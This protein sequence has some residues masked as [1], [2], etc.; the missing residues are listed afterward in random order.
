MT[1]Q[2][3]GVLALQGGFARHGS[4][5]ER[6]GIKPLLVRRADELEQCAGLIIPGG[7]STTMTL[8]MK[9][10]NL[11]TPLKKFASK[12]PIMGTC[13]G[14][15]M[16]STGVD[17]PRVE[18]LDLMDIRADR[19]AYGRQ[20]DSFI[21]YVNTPFTGDEE[22]LKSVFIRAPQLYAM[23]DDVVVLAKLD[24]RA[25]ILEQGRFLA[26]SF[27]PELTDDD[28]IHRYF[29]KKSGLSL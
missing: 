4:M 8:L 7:E 21:T 16:L 14:A 2:F 15:I 10:Y 11:Y 27:H 28:R 23:N 9:K 18:S 13:A 17:D 1:E 19:N 6:M 29:C 26:L 5:L 12:N 24:D 3:I 25:V 22:P 20:R